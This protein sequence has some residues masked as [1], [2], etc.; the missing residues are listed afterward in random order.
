MAC[1]TPSVPPRHAVAGGGGWPNF[2]PIV[3]VDRI[4]T[5]ALVVLEVLTDGA[6]ITSLGLFLATWFARPG[7]A[8]ALSVG[9][10][11]LVANGWPFAFEMFVWRPLQGWLVTNWNMTGA[12]MD[13]ISLSLVSISPLVG[14]A[15]TLDTLDRPAMGQTRWL[16]QLVVLG[17]CLLAWAFAGALYGA[18]LKS[19]DRRLGRMRE[20]SQSG[21]DDGLG[22]LVPDPDGR[23]NGGWRHPGIAV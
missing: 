2:A 10:F 7:R 16:F 12:D 4:A 6:V 5:P 23:Q 15:L 13:W 1:A 20:A 9:A 3:L 19:F 14:P 18:V 17:W 21:R 8:I 22:R 11:G